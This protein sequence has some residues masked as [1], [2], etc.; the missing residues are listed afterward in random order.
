MKRQL[1]EILMKEYVKQ[2]EQLP[3]P[4]EYCYGIC[5][6]MCTGQ[7][8]L[9]KVY[10]SGEE[11]ATLMSEMI[12]FL[13]KKGWYSGCNTFPIVPD[14]GVV[15]NKMNIAKTTYQNYAKARELWNATTE[16]G[17]RRWETY[18]HLDKYLV[19]MRLEAQNG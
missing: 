9:S 10:L 18:L 4:V 16:Y 11:Y 12:K 13:E 1:R 5:F 14:K 7:S 17:R 3:I 15:K 19:R 2:L 6:Y 8:A